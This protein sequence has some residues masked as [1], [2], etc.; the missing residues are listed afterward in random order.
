MNA[1]L[2]RSSDAA[3]GQ[4]R[5]REVERTPRISVTWMGHS[6]VLVEVE[7]VRIGFRGTDDAHLQRDHYAEV[8]GPV[9]RAR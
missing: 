7:G 1:D 4:R 9:D 2:P 3:A 5:T 6:T 8:A